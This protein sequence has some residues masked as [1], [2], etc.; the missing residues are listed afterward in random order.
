VRDASERY[1]E[2]W[3]DAEGDEE[4]ARA[5]FTARAR[6]RCYALRDTAHIASHAASAYGA[7]LLP[8]RDGADV[9][10]ARCVLRYE[11]HDV[12][13]RAR[14]DAASDG[15]EREAARAVMR[16]ARARRAAIRAQ[17]RL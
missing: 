1:T 8:A 13:R 5:A 2:R 15:A 10:I 9:E 3:R 12:E 14:D 6:E 16:R 11:Q 17:I 4:R 7:E